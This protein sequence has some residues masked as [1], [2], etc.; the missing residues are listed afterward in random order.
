MTA[1]THP[2][3]TNQLFFMLIKISIVIISF[4]F[5][6]Y[7]L[8]LKGEIAITDFIHTIANKNIISIENV[9]ILI[10]LTTVNWLLEIMKWKA[11]MSAI[12]KISFKAALEQSLGALTASLFTPNRIGEYGAKALYYQNHLRKSV[13]LINLISNLLQMLVTASLG[14]IGLSLFL[15]QNKIGISYTNLIISVIL[16]IIFI[17]AALGILYKSK[18]TLKGFS[19]EKLKIF[20]F[21]Y[22]K[23]T[24]IKGLV[25]S[26]LRYI[27]FSFQFFIL[28]QLCHIPLAYFEAMVAISTM[29]LIASIIPSVFI[30]DVIVKGSVAVFLFSVLGVDELII[31]SIATMMWLLNFVLPSIIGSYF[32]LNFKLVKNT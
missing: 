12:N 22:P 6:Y 25:I 28:L 17:L 3:K 2:Y 7:K 1:I 26:F 15:V 32:V 14:F 11:L 23:Y 24:L 8:V 18:F 19:I 13:L 10:T 20:I 27:T 21:N 16:C 30:F 9:L 31:L 29:Y 5:I 4:L